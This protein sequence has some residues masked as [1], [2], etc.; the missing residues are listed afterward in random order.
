[1]TLAV[2]ADQY[3]ARV[4]GADTVLDSIE[5]GLERRVAMTGNCEYNYSRHAQP[6]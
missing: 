6:S 5:L 4:L 3:A 2:T 1:V